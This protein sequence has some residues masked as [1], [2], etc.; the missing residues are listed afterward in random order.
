MATASWFADWDQF[1]RAVAFVGVG[2]FL[3]FLAAQSVGSARRMIVTDL[4][5]DRALAEARRVFGMAGW[6]TVYADRFGA[7]YRRPSEISLGTFLFLLVFGFGVFGLA[8]YVMTKSSWDR[9][10][11]SAGTALERNALLI[12]G[13][14]ASALRPIA[15][16]L[17]R[18]L[19]PTVPGGVP[20]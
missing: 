9:V 7:S 6:E 3:A 16:V 10:T 15:R 18:E 5:Q 20:A 11:V 4:P 1:A 13:K 2:V 14:P 12:S 8:Y 19:A 17:T